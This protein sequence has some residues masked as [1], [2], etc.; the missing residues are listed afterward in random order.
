MNADRVDKAKN[1]VKTIASLVEDKEKA[2]RLEDTLFLIEQTASVIV[3]TNELMHYLL[4]EEE[5]LDSQNIE[6]LLTTRV[7]PLLEEYHTA[8]KKVNGIS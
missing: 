6:S 4:S 3:S 2:E 7:A 8:L 1:I 5:S